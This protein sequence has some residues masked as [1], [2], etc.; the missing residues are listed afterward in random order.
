MKRLVLEDITRPCKGEFSIT[1]YRDGKPIKTISDHNLVVER[2][3]VRLAEL[4]AGKSTAYITQIGVGEGATTEADDDT[5]LTNQALFPI[6]KASV[7]G[8]DARFDFTI[9]NTQGNGLKI[10]EFGLFCA[11]GAMFSH[12]VRKGVIEKADDIQIRGCWIIH[13]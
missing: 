5:E 3:R 10:H 1:I 13:F 11:D 8:R 2:G 7:D 12:R 9:D 4:A 6:D